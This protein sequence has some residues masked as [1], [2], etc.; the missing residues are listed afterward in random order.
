M[1][2]TYTNLKFDISKQSASGIGITNNGTHFL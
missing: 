2:G 1:N